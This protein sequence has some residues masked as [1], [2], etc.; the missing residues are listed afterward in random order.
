MRSDFSL[1]TYRIKTKSL[2]M[3]YGFNCLE[4]CAASISESV[5]VQVTRLISILLF[6]FFFSVFFLLRSIGV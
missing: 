5:Q 1:N 2:G 6:F 3:D 4:W